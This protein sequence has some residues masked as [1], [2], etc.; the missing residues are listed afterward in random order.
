MADGEENRG[1]RMAIDRKNGSSESWS[2]ASGG[3]AAA[4]NQLLA[5]HVP[6]VEA[7]IRYRMPPALATRESVS[8]LTQSLVGDL[9]PELPKT[10]FA[11]EAA[12]HGWL[13]ACALNKIRERL[14]FW[15]AER[16]D[17][18]E[19]AMH[20]IGPD[21]LPG[22]ATSPSEAL[23]RSESEERLHE[24]LEKLPEDQRDLVV[25]VK[26]C[27]VSYEEAAEAM[28]RSPSACRKVVSRAMVKLS[29]LLPD[30]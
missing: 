5:R 10:E 15:R 13:R 29:S 7:F 22:R 23:R 17:G 20:D 25:M 3:D 9:I 26:L 27:G 18:V 30:A 2:R 28:D 14:R 21:P 11:N 8:D 24:A 4:L 12:F 1:G 16:R 6:E 19:R